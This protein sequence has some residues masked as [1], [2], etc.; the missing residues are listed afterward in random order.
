M[1][2]FER[3]LPTPVGLMF[4][5]APLAIVPAGPSW[6]KPGPLVS[7][8]AM[9]PTTAL[10]VAGRLSRVPPVGLVAGALSPPGR[11]SRTRVTGVQGTNRPVLAGGALASVNQPATS[12]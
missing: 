5:V 9:L 8:T 7:V 6:T 2:A 1:N 4:A 11:V 3:V 10:P 12:T